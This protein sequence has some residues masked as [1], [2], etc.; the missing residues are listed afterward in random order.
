MKNK[1]EKRRQEEEEKEQN[2]II[3]MMWYVVVSAR[4]CRRPCHTPKTNQIPIGPRV[5]V[6]FLL[7][8]S[9]HDF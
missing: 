1:T 6:S 8:K 2:I 5:L 9:T 3:M 7:L 4:V